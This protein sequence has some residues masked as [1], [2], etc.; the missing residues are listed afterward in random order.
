MDAPSLTL[1]RDQDRLQRFGAA[2]YR[3]FGEYENDRKQLEDK[4]LKNLRQF[5]GQYDPDAA[6]RIPADQSSAYPKY[7]R[8]KV[9]G[10]LARLMQIAFPQTEENYSVKPSPQP[11]L[12]TADTQEVLNALQAERRDPQ[13]GAVPDLSNE[14]IEK[15]IMVRAKERAERMMLTIRDQLAEIDY[16]SRARQVM[17]SAIIFNAGVL[18]GPL[19]R[20]D[21]TRKWRRDP[22]TAV[23]TATEVD[24]HKPYFENMP[25]WEYYPDLSAKTRDTQDGF[26]RRHVMNRSQVRKLADRPDY[27]GSEILSWLKN[28]PKGNFRE[29]HWE[30]D[31]RSS[32]KDRANISDLSGRKYELIEW[33]GSVSAHD[34]VAAGV[35]VPE[36]K[37]SEE[38]EANVWAIDQTI[39]KAVLNPYDTEIRPDHVFVFEDDDSSLLGGGL[40]DVLRDTQLSICESSRMLLDNASVTCGPMLEVNDELLRPGQ[41]SAVHARKIWHR[42]GSGAEAGIPAVRSI[43][44]DAH[45]AELIS[46]I[47]LFMSF[48]DMESNLPPPAIGDL[49]QGG[50]EALRTTGGASMLLG[51]AAL[52][53][54]DTLRNFDQFTQ[55]VV[56]ALVS[57]N[58]EFNT[59]ETIKGD[60]QVIAR[61]ST[62]LIAKEVLAQALDYLSTTMTQEERMHVNTRK[63][64]IK[65]MEVRDVP[66][67]DVLED[68]T[69]V[70]QKLTQ[71]AQ[72]ANQQQADQAELVRAQVKE[73]LANAF[74]SVAKGRAA[75]ASAN[76]QLY[77]AILEGIDH[78]T[79]AADKRAGGGTGDGASG[80]IERAGG[81][82]NAPPAWE[83]SIQDLAAVGAL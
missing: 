5:K 81:T 8:T 53:I 42:E 64:L 51:A 67:D 62:S 29:R 13:T 6:A 22:S 41:S 59:D 7:T 76:T 15:A 33:W 48:G 56:S 78:A 32:S 54:R 38:V 19:V 70:E 43:S 30:A 68:E 4:W 1:P 26:F 57:W 63:L 79:G 58:M 35:D 11:D 21:K 20:V 52:P 18:V 66:V 16:V 46:V 49:S 71:Q 10:T 37:M 74:E 65:R 40:P 34:L 28:N 50:S 69:I 83:P 80:K 36:G 75:D 45:I 72:A 60:Y 44:A 39:I 12:S 24:G 14:E 31:L 77:Q 25:L 27:L 55:S 3:R 82:G 9:V 73:I 61:S 23:Y 17:L 47:N 2:F